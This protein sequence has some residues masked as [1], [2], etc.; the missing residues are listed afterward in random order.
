GGGPGP[1]GGGAIP[2]HAGAADG[3]VSAARQR[4]G[5]RRVVCRQP[6][7][8]MPAP[9]VH[10]RVDAGAAVAGGRRGGGGMADRPPLGLSLASASLGRR[11]LL[12]QAGYS[13]DVLPSD[14]DEPSGE[15][16]RDIRAFVHQVAWMKAAAVAPRV[17]A[18]IILA[19]DSVGWIGGHVIAK[20]ADR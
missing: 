19:A 2:L 4:G 6:A 11:E 16:V 1:A 7:Q 18:N 5:N 9:G 8:E 10:E 12:R 3:T 15:D 13:F 20:P 14:V 17:D